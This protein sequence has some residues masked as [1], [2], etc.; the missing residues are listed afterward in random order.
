MKGRLG[1]LTWEVSNNQS[2][3]SQRIHIIGR[4]CD[5]LRYDSSDYQKALMRLTMYDTCGLD[6]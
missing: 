2:R 4:L 3:G 1:L 6:R 5:Y